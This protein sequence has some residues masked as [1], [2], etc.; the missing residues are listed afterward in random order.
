MANANFQVESHAAYLE[1]DL[2]FLKSDP[3]VA[4]DPCF[5]PAL[6]Y[7]EK[8]LKA[9]KLNTQAA[10]KAYDAEVKYL[11]FSERYAGNAMVS[12][13]NT[14][15]NKVN[16]VMTD[17]EPDLHALANSL[18]GA[19]PQSA[20]TLA[21]ITSASS[22]ASAA[23]AATLKVEIPVAP[24]G[25]PGVTPKGGPVVAPA[26][27]GPAHQALQ[28][29]LGELVGR[30]EALQWNNYRLSDATETV[31]NL[32]PDV[33]KPKTESCTKLFD[34]P[35]VAPDVLTLNPDGYISLTQGEKKKVTIS[36]GKLPFAVRLMCD[37]KGITA[38][39]DYDSG[40]AVIEIGASASADANSYPLMVTDSTGIGRP[41]IIV[42]SK[43]ADDS[44]D[45]PDCTAGGSEQTGSASTA[46]VNA[47]A[48]LASSAH[49]YAAAAAKAAASAKTAADRAEKSHKVADAAAASRAASKAYS[50]AGN[51]QAKAGAADVKAATSKDPIIQSLSQAADVQAQNANTSASQA[52]ADAARAAATVQKRES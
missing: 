31:I 38:E 32:T 46:E 34:Q 50:A 4:A 3:R 19:I 21:G 11:Q 18:S 47:I 15:N 2:T 14:I 52:A 25:T 48:G 44:A 49:A 20:Q 9:A 8:A 5:K 36:G 1:E 7:A 28:S 23:A 41:L 10:S 29:E 45:T 17:T 43:K 42:V 13:T 37:C 27:K 51:A 16:E 35:G 39:T 6:C 24:P 26:C 33:I 30:S 12:V 40:K 22:A